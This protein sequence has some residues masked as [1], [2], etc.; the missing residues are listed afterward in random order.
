MKLLVFV[1]KGV[2]PELLETLLWLA[3]PALLSLGV[4][5]V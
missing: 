1:A 5:A 4:S 2:G 3:F